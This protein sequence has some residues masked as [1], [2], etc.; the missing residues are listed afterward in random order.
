MSNK[1][2]LFFGFSYITILL[3]FLY[4]IFSY[5]EPSRINDFVYYKEL[6]KDLEIVINENFYLNLLF[7]FIFCLVWVSLLGFG[8][9]L[10]I[11]SGILFGKWIGTAISVFSISVGA[12]CLYFIANFFFKDI[13]RNLLETKF[14]K[15]INLF[16]KNEFIYFFLFRLVG[17]LGI[18]F[19]LQNVLP[20]IFD[21]KKVNY[22]FASFFGFIP[23]FF[24]WNTI[25]SGLN[26]YIKQ[27][28]SFSFI[29]LI[30][31]KEIYVP[32]FFFIIFMFFS[33]LIKKKF[34]D[35]NSL[36]SENFKK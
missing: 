32:I 28:D 17:G 4:F 30:F 29:N 23:V 36:T 16:K 21:I 35:K 6:Q 11:V 5:I 27:S 20:I 2:K 26:T 12:L 1:L 25:G 10:L 18:P 22:F 15:Y 7:F 34:F 14:K 31:N 3:V 24:I 9:P 13:V 19:G 8:S 33:T